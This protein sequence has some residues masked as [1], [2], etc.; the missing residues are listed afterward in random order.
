VHRHDFA[1]GAYLRNPAFGSV[2]RGTGAFCQSSITD[3]WIYGCGLG[4]DNGFQ[5]INLQSTTNVVDIADNQ[6]CSADGFPTGI[7]CLR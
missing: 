1:P 4:Q 2:G 6:L 7:P 3:N 5:A